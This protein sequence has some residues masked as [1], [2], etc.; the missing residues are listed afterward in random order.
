M[1]INEQMGP[2]ISQIVF[3]LVL[4]DLTLEN[5]SLQGENKASEISFLILDIL[6]YIFDHLKFFITFLN[7]D[8]EAILNMLISL[9]KK[10]KLD[11]IYKT[12]K[13]QEEIYSL[14]WSRETMNLKYHNQPALI[15]K[16]DEIISNTNKLYFSSENIYFQSELIRLPAEK[17]RG[18]GR[19]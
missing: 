14:F 9:S 1:K 4:C 17:P 6:A 13:F 5:G 8:F 15:A 18:P 2:G 19:I 3:T 12:I 7:D 11:I 16:I 10:S